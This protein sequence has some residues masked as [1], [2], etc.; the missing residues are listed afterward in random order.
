MQIHAQ[1]REQSSGAEGG[2]SFARNQTQYKERCRSQQLQTNRE[3]GSRRAWDVCEVLASIAPRRRLLCQA[4]KLLDCTN[5]RRTQGA[6][7]I[8][9]SDTPPRARI[10]EA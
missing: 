10:L 3:P 7:H 9:T 5:M 6:T 4:T 2:I 1:W 8:L